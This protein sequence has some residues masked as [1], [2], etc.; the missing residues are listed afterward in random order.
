MDKWVISIIDKSGFSYYDTI[1]MPEIID[2]GNT[3]NIVTNM[4]DMFLAKDNCTIG[5][6]IIQYQGKDI[7]VILSPCQGLT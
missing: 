5:D 4:G 2:L 1:D 7:N 3:Y 6:D